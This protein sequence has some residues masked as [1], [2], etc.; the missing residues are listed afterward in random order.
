MA[1]LSLSSSWR[2]CDAPVNCL[3]L[4]E[5]AARAKRSENAREQ[6]EDDHLLSSPE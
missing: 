2:I 4:V 5:Q 1:D 3:G 6:H